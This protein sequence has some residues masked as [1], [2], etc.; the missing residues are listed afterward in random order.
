M[1]VSQMKL[2]VSQMRWKQRIVECLNSGVPV[3]G[4]P[5]KLFL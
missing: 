5:V 3:K 1:Q 2:A 4:E